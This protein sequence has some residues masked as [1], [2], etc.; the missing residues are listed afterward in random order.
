MSWPREGEG[1]SAR[2]ILDAVSQQLA[3][4][5]SMSV[6]QL[7][8]RYL[9]IVG[10]PLRGRNKPYLKKKLAW[11]IQEQAEGGLSDRALQQ[12]HKLAK[13]AAI[14]TRRP[15]VQQA[16]APEQLP[17][18]SDSPTRDSRLPPV[19]EVLTKVYKGTEHRVLMLAD[20][21]EYQGARYKSLSKVA[22][23][24]TGTAWNGFLFFDLAKRKRNA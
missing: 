12:I 21:F 10:E 4:L 14:R 5:D 9:E 16:A 24:I 19:G 6:K 11:A 18:S 3:A 7:Q 22:R 17:G 15:S 23:E 13:S 20:G 2:D 8:E 1:R